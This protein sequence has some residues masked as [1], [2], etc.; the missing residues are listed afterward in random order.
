M[1]GRGFV[2]VG[3]SGPYLAGILFDSSVGRAAMRL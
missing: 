1:Q 2:A 3:P